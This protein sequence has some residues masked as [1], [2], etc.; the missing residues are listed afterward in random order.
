M[1]RQEE[2]TV[3]P[4]ARLPLTGAAAGAFSA[5]VFVAVHDLLISDIWFSLI[6]ML[7]SG[8]LCGGAVAWTYALLFPRPTFAGWLGYNL[9][10]FAVLVAMGLV[11]LLIYE[12]VATAATLIAAGGAPTELIRQATPLSVVSIVLAT[13]LIHRLWGRGVGQFLALL[14]C[15]TLVMVLLGLNVSVLGLVEFDS[16]GWVLVLY[17]YALTLLLNVIYLGTFAGM[18]RRVFREGGRAS[19]LRPGPME[20]SASTST[21]L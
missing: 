13:A 6:P 4:T 11:S 10:Y 16:Q 5:V 1:H 7:V 8:A 14:L 17:T 21:R 19:A 12:P 3:N 2:R 9:V 20:H 18:E 15:C